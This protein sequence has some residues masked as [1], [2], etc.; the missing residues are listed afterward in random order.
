MSK[1]LVRLCVLSVSLLTPSPLL[2]LPTVDE[3]LKQMAARETEVHAIEADVINV[4]HMSGSSMRG[5]GKTY[6]L[7]AEVDG[8]KVRKTA[9]TADLGIRTPRGIVTALNLKFVTDGRFHWEE[10]RRTATKEVRVV[11]MRIDQGGC[12]PGPGETVEELK[13][14][15]DFSRV[16]EEIIDDQNL[17]ILEG[18]PKAGL[19]DIPQAVKVKIY[20]DPKT[21]L[22]RRF[23][24]LNKAD[25][26]T[27][28]LEVINIKV[29]GEVDPGLF[30]YTPP[31][32]AHI[33]DRTQDPAGE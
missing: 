30:D 4:W 17:Y 23:V 27:M 33:E 28:S 5:T 6:M 13:R 7:E 32:E 21:L 29:N 11:K 14:E 2:A 8:K 31:A 3:L 19:P 12:A 15:F 22:F 24:A 16:S 25:Q 18:T 20:V 26:E 9:T 1:H 10:M